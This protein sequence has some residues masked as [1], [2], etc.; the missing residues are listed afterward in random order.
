MPPELIGQ[1]QQMAEK[2]LKSQQSACVALVGDCV[3]DRFVFGSVD[4]ISPEA[5]VPVLLVTQSRDELGC[6][7]NVAR[8]VAALADQSSRLSLKLVSLIGSDAEGAW[9]QKRLAGMGAQVS[10]DLVQDAQWPTPLKTRFVAGAHHQMLRV[11]RENTAQV[12]SA[13]STQ[14]L[15]KKMQSLIGVSD[16][17]IVQDYAKGALSDESLKSLLSESR[18]L[19]KRTLVDPNRN[20]RASAYE[21]AWIVTPNVAE[22]E[23]MLGRSLEK[24][25]SDQV[26]ERA[27]HDLKKT[28]GLSAAMITR[29]SYGLTFVDDRDQVFHLKAFARQVFDVTGA[30]DTLVAVL[31][32]FL[33]LGLDLHSSAILANAAASVVV[34]KVGTATATYDEIL[35][36]LSQMN[37]TR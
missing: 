16:L 31:G 7:A 20:R 25:A 17:L 6:V 24:G 14:A 18:R 13:Q 21:Q 15:H 33:A 34:A 37:A 23:V 27:C 22:A 11:D 2:A 5:P 4:R 28:L 10:A 36:E 30:G 29:S 32:T 35:N 3:V 12:L 9:I 1:V 19:K 8:N 26:I